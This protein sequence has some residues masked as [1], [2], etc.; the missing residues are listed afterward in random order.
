[1]PDYTPPPSSYVDPRD[2]HAQQVQDFLKKIST[3]ES[4]SGTNTNH[5]MVNSGMHSGTAAVGQYGLMTL[6]AQDLDRQ[7]KINKLQDMQPNEVS[8]K[9]KEDP[10][11]QDQLASSL[12]DKLLIKKTPEEAAYSWEHGQYS[13]PT[14]DELENSG[15]V[16]SFRV[17]NGT[18]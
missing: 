12:A 2:Y 15:R 1:M 9:L 11:L 14:P 7:F 13:K 16:R 8:D 5:Q 10:E 17:L 4:S 3:L 18:K 6:T